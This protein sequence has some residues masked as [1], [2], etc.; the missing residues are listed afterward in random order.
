M[1]SS[2]EGTNVITDGRSTDA[3]MDLKVHVVAEGDDDLLDL[4]GELAGRREDEG[5]ALAE[6]GIEFREGTNGKGGGFTLKIWRCE[7]V[8]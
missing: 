8:T 4:L 1:D 3:G 2:L 6:F 5:L 7:K